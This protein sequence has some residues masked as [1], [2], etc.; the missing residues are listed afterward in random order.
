MK[1][2]SENQKITKLT[3][4][5]YDKIHNNQIKHRKTILR[6]KSVLTQSLIKNKLEKNIINKICGDFGCGNTGNGGEV[7]LKLKAKKVHFM[8]LNNSIKAPL[9]K[10]FKKNKKKIEI[11]VGN[12][13]KMKFKNE[14]FDFIICQGV[15]HHLT[16]DKKAFKEVYRV[17]KKGG[18]FYF[19][20][21]GEGGLITEFFNSILKKNYYKNKFQKKILDEIIYQKK[22]NFKILKKDLSKKEKNIFNFVAKYFDEDFFLTLRDR[23]LSPIYRQY[24]ETKLIFFLK[25]VGFKNIRRIKRKPKYENIRK[26]FSPLYYDYNNDL[27]KLFFGEGNIALI[28]EK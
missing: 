17:L 14:S 27:A 11:N 7:L 13:E 24:N 3:R 1:K 5:I 25:K 9:L 28:V 6:M 21:Q 12:L 18:Y 10:K 26:L 23:I 15:F 20:V 2:N 8:D 22:D 19:D 4:S 16:N